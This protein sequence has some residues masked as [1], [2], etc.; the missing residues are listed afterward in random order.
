[1][2]LSNSSHGSWLIAVGLH[3][4]ST[5]P[6]SILQSPI[7]ILNSHAH[8]TSA[9]NRTAHS[10]NLGLYRLTHFSRQREELRTLHTWLTH[11]VRTAPWPSP[12]ARAMAKST[13]LASAAAWANIRHFSDGVISVGPAGQDRF[14][15]Y[16]IVRTPGHGPGYHH[17]WYERGPLGYCDFGTALSTQTAADSGRLFRSHGDGTAHPRRDRQPPAGIRQLVRVLLINRTSNPM[18]ADLVHGRELM[19]AGLTQPELPAYITAQA[20]APWISSPLNIW[21]TCI[22][23]AEAVRLGWAALG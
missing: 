12:A 17:L 10:R 4:A 11:R 16:D 2:N 20:P 3:V 22:G 21:P 18:I 5:P 6:F 19:L 13:P 8:Q 14:R 23:S 9:R 7:S 15:L 1:M